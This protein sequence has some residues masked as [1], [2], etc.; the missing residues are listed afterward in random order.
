MQTGWRHQTSLSYETAE[1]VFNAN[2]GQPTGCRHYVD[3]EHLDADGT[4]DDET[5]DLKIAAPVARNEFDDAGDPVNVLPNKSGDLGTLRVVLSRAVGGCGLCQLVWH[6]ACS[7]RRDTSEI[8]VVSAEAPCKIRFSYNETNLYLPDTDNLPAHAP[9]SMNTTS[10]DTKSDEG[11]SITPERHGRFNCS[12]SIGQSFETQLLLCTDPLGIEWFGGRLYGPV[13]DYSLVRSWLS[14]CD[15]HHPRCS[16]NGNPFIGNAFDTLRVIDVRQKCLADIDIAKCK[17]VALSYVWGQIEMLTTTKETVR[18]FYRPGA[19]DSPAQAIPTTIR[20][21]MH[22][23]KELNLDYLWTDSLCI[24]QDDDKEKRRLIAQMD[25][26]YASAHFTI[27]VADGVDANAGLAGSH[28]GAARAI[29][30]VFRCGQQVELFASPDT[31]PDTLLRCPWSSRAWT[32]Q[33][34]L[35][36]RRLLV[37]TRSTVHFTCNTV[38]WSEDQKS[39]SETFP[40]PRNH[41]QD[42]YFDFRARL[43]AEKIMDVPDTG[44]MW[45]LMLWVETVMDLSTRRL[46]YERD[47]LFAAAGIIRQLEKFYRTYSLSGLPALRLEQFLS[48]SP[49]EEEGLRR[50][51]DVDGTIVNPSW[52]WSGWVG[53]VGWPGGNSSIVE[54]DAVEVG[55]STMRDLDAAAVP[56]P[57]R[58]LVERDSGCADLHID[59]PFLQIS[60]L[61]SR[62][63]VSSGVEPPPNIKDLQP[64]SWYAVLSDRAVARSAPAPILHPD[65]SDVFLGSVIFDKA[66]YL[67]SI[68]E[69]SVGCDFIISS[70]QAESLEYGDYAGTVFHNVLAILQGNGRKKP[71]E[72][73]GHGRVLVEESRGLWEQDIVI[74]A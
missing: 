39:R 53:E 72:R 18:S 5:L 73:I 19:L 36:S 21:A 41:A 54:R 6:V 28:A 2:D 29:P 58:Q 55:I 67:Q 33:E 48:W 16:W 59:A 37:F 10:D 24:M 69:G 27:A 3:G 57:Q 43:G 11:P 15:H 31:L 35:L 30:P 32:L 7:V 65:H 25:A 26:V 12:V 13:V 52:S 51:K 34:A 4:Y 71:L 49:M 42:R 45:Y 38:A 46:T 1:D 50:R 17:Y 70:S 20:D 61:R 22:V 62:L 60:T 66:D 44:T 40:E 47:V 68:A 23:V 64:F 8:G 56:I 63:V 14:A 74:L 9:N